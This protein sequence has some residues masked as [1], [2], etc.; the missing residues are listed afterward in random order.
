M[1]TCAWQ[2]TKPPAALTVAEFVVGCNGQTCARVDGAQAPDAHALAPQEGG[3]PPQSYGL[4]PPDRLTAPAVRRS[5]LVS[6]CA[7][8][9]AFTGHGSAHAEPARAWAARS[10]AVRVP[11]GGAL[12]AHA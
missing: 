9:L 2:T 1:S 10:H 12:P 3:T 11:R 4:L 7:L 5:A 6:T 8:V